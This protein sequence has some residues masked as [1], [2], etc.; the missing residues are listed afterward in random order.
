M[1][2]NFVAT[3][4]LTRAAGMATSRTRL[5]GVASTNPDS[6]NIAEI[7]FV[8]S[9]SALT[10]IALP[11][12]AVTPSLS[13]LSGPT[14][15]S[16]NDPSG[17]VTVSKIVSSGLSSMISRRTC[18]KLVETV[19]PPPMPR[20]GRLERAH[21]SIRTRTPP[22]G[23]PAESTSVAENGAGMSSLSSTG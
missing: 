4:P 9:C 7:P 2:G 23:R 5:S 15:S 17:L 21:I 3:R 18:M 11:S 6:V 1:P 19:E 8:A 14:A 20:C 10:R 12:A 13:Q 22:T 16:V